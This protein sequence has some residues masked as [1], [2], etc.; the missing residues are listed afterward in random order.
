MKRNLQ[1]KLLLATLALIVSVAFATSTTYA[2]FTTNSRVES[3]D[4]NMEAI[5]FGEMYIQNVGGEGENTTSGAFDTFNPGTDGSKWS[6]DI[7]L[8]SGT[9]ELAP[10]TM[11]SAAATETSGSH[12]LEFESPNMKLDDTPAV[13]TKDFVIASSNEYYAQLSS[14]SFNAVGEREVVKAPAYYFYNDTKLYRLE[15]EG[16]TYTVTDNGGVDGAVRSEITENVTTNGAITLPDG[17]ETATV[18]DTTAKSIDITDYT[19]IQLDEEIEGV[20][21]N[22]VRVA[23]LNQANGK[24]VVF[25]PY[26][27]EGFEKYTNL[28]I[29]HDLYFMETEEEIDDAYKGPKNAEVEFV[30]SAVGS[31]AA[32]VALTETD[33]DSGVFGAHLSLYVWLEGTDADNFDAVKSKAFSLSFSLEGVL[34]T[35]TETETRPLD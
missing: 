33:T 12:K 15:I 13:F 16:N 35:G 26:T 1:K 27:S 9:N 8:G 10:V 25:N 11:K 31:K 3:N 2:W 30:D 19:V 28:N 21:E 17:T 22:S 23:F 20:I 6:T 32:L 4:V 34:L 24:Y 29:A 18:T 5:S 14:L 7:N